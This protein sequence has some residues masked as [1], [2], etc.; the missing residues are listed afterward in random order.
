MKSELKFPF[1]V[2]TDSHR[3]KN[4]G[5]ASVGVLITDKKEVAID[6]IFEIRK[7]AFP[8]TFIAE[9]TGFCKGISVIPQ[10]CN[11]KLSS[12]YENRKTVVV[13]SDYKDLIELMDR[14]MGNGDVDFLRKKRNGHGNSKELDELERIIESVLEV[15]DSYEIKY[16][17]IEGGGKNPAHY[18]CRMAEGRLAQD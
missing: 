9:A 1:K 4:N 3:L 8:S 15:N 14:K 7:L 18:L 16:K 5:T 11:E 12:E 10:Y 17:K 6:R 2:Y 13:R